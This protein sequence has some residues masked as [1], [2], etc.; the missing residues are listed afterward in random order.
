MCWSDWF[1]PWILFSDLLSWGWKQS[2]FLTAFE[3]RRRRCVHEH[4]HLYFTNRRLLQNP[5]S[6]LWHFKAGWAPESPIKRAALHEQAQS[7][8]EMSPHSEHNPG[9][10]HYFCLSP[11]LMNERKK[12]QPLCLSQPT[13]L[14]LESI[15][16]AP[17]KT[18]QQNPAAAPDGQCAG[19]A[20]R[21]ESSLLEDFIQEQNQRVDSNSFSGYS[22]G[23][24]CCL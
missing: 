1:K 15:R 18:K 19:Q 6:W 24:L 16:T 17:Q 8:E 21:E 22:F 13:T 4:A 11:P 20:G 9:R 10:P 2:P 14:P 7:P 12:M 5:T 23:Q 3:R